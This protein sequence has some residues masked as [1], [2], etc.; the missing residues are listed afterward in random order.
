LPTGET[1]SNINTPP[2][3]PLVPA[4]EEDDGPATGDDGFELTGTGV[5]AEV[6]VLL[7]LGPLM[8]ADDVEADE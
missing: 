6:F 2:P 5:P 4:A 3:L 1:F 8:T 7:L